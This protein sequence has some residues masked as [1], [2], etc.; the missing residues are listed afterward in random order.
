PSPCP[1]LKRSDSMSHPGN[2]IDQAPQPQTAADHEHVAIADA[3]ASLRASRWDIAL[4]C[5]ET[6]LERDL[7]PSLRPLGLVQRLSILPSFI[8]ALA[9][10]LTRPRPTRDLGTNPVL[11]RLARD[12]VVAREQA[13][14]T[15]REVVQ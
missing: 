15:A 4:A 7:L 12:H 10:S 2:D 11:A 13:G 6:A 14:F 9:S 1:L 3:A 8:G 5:V